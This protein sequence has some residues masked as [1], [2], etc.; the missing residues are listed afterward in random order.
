MKKQDTSDEVANIVY[1]SIGSNLGNKVLNIE[2]TKYLLLRKNIKILYCSSFYETLSWP[3]PKFPRFLNIVIKINTTLD[4]KDLFLLIKSIE[5]KIGR[6]KSAKNYPRLCDIDIIDFNNKNL[7]FSSKD[8]KIIIPH[9]RMHN[10]NF[11][12]IPMYQI[13]KNWIHPKKSE[14]I[15]DLLSKLSF[16][17]IRGIKVI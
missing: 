12:L 4:P 8:Q 13:N 14:K 17:S 16:N 1:L 6:R 2:K 15:T 9:P 7:N 5:K 10:R 11:V 3:N